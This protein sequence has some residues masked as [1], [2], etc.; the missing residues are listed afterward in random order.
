MLVK[1]LKSLL[2]LKGAS[3]G[4]SQNYMAVYIFQL[5]SNMCTQTHIQIQYLTFNSH[6]PSTTNFCERITFLFVICSARRC[7]LHFTRLVF[8]F[9][10]TSFFLF[11]TFNTNTKD[12]QHE[13]C[14]LS[15]VVSNVQ[16]VGMQTISLSQGK[17]CILKSQNQTI[18]GNRKENYQL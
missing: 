13:S 2:C 6:L 15:C 10:S 14:Q 3:C 8:F 12:S 5:H 7:C 16:G 11:K 9:S 1:K 17:T 18:G 4:F